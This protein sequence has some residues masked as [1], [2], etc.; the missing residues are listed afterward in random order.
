MAGFGLMHWFVCN[1]TK[2]I[3]LL[4]AWPK[5]P[6]E[7][8]HVVHCEAHEY[9][10]NTVLLLLLVVCRY[11]LTSSWGPMWVCSVMQ[12]RRSIC[13]PALTCCTVFFLLTCE[14]CLQD[15]KWLDR[16]QAF[17]SFMVSETGKADW[18]TPDHPASLFEGMAGGLCLLA[19]LQAATAGA[20]EATAAEQQAA[21]AALAPAGSQQQQQQQQQQAGVGSRQHEAVCRLVTYPLFELPG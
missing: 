5:R 14:C 17:A 9:S 7:L 1:F 20:T 12:W 10:L 15:T 18:H 19:E 3:C 11:T 4:H 16:A 8:G 6:W 13:C 2:C 21:A